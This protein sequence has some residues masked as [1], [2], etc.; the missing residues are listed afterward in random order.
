MAAGA[1]DPAAA[2]QLHGKA[3]APPPPLELISTP[4]DPLPAGSDCG[5][6]EGGGG[7]RGEGGSVGERLRRTCADGDMAGL[8]ALL[9][10]GLLTANVLN[11]RYSRGR[12]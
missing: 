2:P 7:G 10:S 9:A 4:S 11:S 6:R 3:F 12:A 5:D 1:T 8:E